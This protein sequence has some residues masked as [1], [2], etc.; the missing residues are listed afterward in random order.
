MNERTLIQTI[1]THAQKETLT[2]TNFLTLTN[3]D[4][5]MI[6]MMKIFTD[7]KKPV[8]LTLSWVLYYI[9]DLAIADTD[10]FDA[11]QHTVTH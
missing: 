7:N 3:V 1:F 5:L 8:L 9:D 10:F 2:D 11:L 4:D 6:Q